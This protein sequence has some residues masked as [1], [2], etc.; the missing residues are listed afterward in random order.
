MK[1]CRSTK[2][3]QTRMMVVG[4]SSGAAAVS[5]LPAL[6]LVCQTEI[7]ISLYRN[8]Q[9]C[10][11][12]RRS[13]R[14]RHHHGRIRVTAAD[15]ETASERAETGGVERGETRARGAAAGCARDAQARTRA[16]SCGR[17]GRGRSETYR[18]SLRFA[19]LKAWKFVDIRGEKA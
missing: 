5:S 11:G 19:G 6:V 8:Q 3:R 16:C 10:V 4:A 1:A 14:Y 15:E 18:I 17:A 13:F 7:I 12:G 2:T 9:G